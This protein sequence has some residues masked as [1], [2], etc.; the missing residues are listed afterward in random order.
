LPATRARAYLVQDHEPEFYATSAEARWSEATYELGFHHLCG[1]PWLEEMAGRYGGTT[2]RFSFGIEHDV[3]FPR[4]VP[5]R[6][7]T[8][9]LYGRDSTP[10]RAVPLALLALEELLERRPGT[11]IASFGSD[12]SIYAPF[13]YEDL[14]VLSLEQLAWTFSEGTVGLVLSM[15][16]YS[17]IPQEMLAC[18]M[19]CVELAGVSGEGIFGEDGGVAFAEFDPLSIAD[20]LERLLDDEAEWQRRSATG[21]EWARGRTWDLGARQVEAGLREALRLRMARPAVAGG[22]AD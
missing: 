7:D 5:R 3:Y 21:I 13:A 1:S 19:P 15:T 18:G 11:R 17:V 2:S 6:R 12:M 10:R 20:A 14:G 4:P 22:G 9:V 16:N 8:V